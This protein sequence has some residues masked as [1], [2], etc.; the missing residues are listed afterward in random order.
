MSTEG[1]ELEELEA[2]AR[3]KEEREEIENRI[4]QARVEVLAALKDTNMQAAQNT[5][6]GGPTPADVFADY[7]QWREVTPNTLKNERYRF[8]KYLRDSVLFKTPIRLLDDAHAFELLDAMQRDGVPHTPRKEAAKTLS[9]MASYFREKRLRSGGLLFQSLKV[10]KPRTTEDD[11]E[12][13]LK[14]EDFLR[15]QACEDISQDDRDFIAF[16]FL[17]G[18]RKSTILHMPWSDIDLDAGSVIERYGLDGGAMK[19]GKPHRKFIPPAALEML[20]ARRERTGGEGL[21]FPNRKGKA[22]GRNYDAHFRANLE[23]AGVDADLTFHSTR[24]GSACWLISEGWRLEAVQE[25][26]GHSSIA[27]TQRYAKMMP[28]EMKAR[29]AELTLVSNSGS[30]PP[31]SDDG[32][33]RLGKVALYR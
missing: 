27:V 20:R 18:S 10:K 1:Y 23:K 16:G 2:E 11:F 32:S 28:A 4:H 6:E 13:Y 5:H 26:L 19:S 7:Q 21:V 25:Y 3:R 31:E 14:L 12:K 24:H 33:G 15:L 9:Q 8:E 30:T 22:F 17:I 29:A